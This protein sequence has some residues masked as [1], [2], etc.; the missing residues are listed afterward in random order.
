MKFDK[1]SAEVSSSKDRH[2]LSVAFLANANPPKKTG[3]ARFKSALGGRK[4]EKG[5]WRLGQ[6]ERIEKAA[7]AGLPHS[8]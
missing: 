6:I 5:G 2:R 3:R 1:G 8:Y 4:R 7:T